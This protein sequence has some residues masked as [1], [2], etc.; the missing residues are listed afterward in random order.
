M[1][2]MELSEAMKEAFTEKLTHPHRDVR[3]PECGSAIELTYAG[4]SASGRL[5]CPSCKA[6]GE[7][8]GV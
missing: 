6:F 4:H 1:A 3:C 7:F 8:R 2:Y 5:E